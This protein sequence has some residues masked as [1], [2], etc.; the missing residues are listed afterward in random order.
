MKLAER[1]TCASVANSVANHR[2]RL[3]HSYKYFL[4]VCA[5]GIAYLKPR[6]ISCR[7]YIAKIIGIVA[8]GTEDAY[9]VW[10]IF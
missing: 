8:A 3:I 7:I 2:L 1:Q 9:A 6:Y 5:V 10:R 4:R